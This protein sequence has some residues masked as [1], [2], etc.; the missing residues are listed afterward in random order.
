M[1]ITVTD[2]TGATLPGI[3]VEAVGVADRTGDTDESG[4]LRFTNLRPGAYR[5]R[6][7]GD[8][9]ITFEREIAVRNG[10]TTDVDVT[11]NPD[12]EPEEASE[13]APQA[14]TP[15]AAAPQLGPAG[16]PMTLDI[17]EFADR[18]LIRREPRRESPIACSGNARATL[19]QLNEPQPERLYDTAE[20]MYYVVAG[21]G[22]IRV[23]GRESALVAGTFAL[24][25]R[26]ASFTI[27]RKG[28]NPIV[29]LSVLTGEPCQGQ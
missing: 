29:L 23:N 11:L 3:H 9:V 1:T 17:P 28:R 24:V 26:G 10:Q 6:F 13:S 20:S 5:M 27:L 15:Q 21:E 2:P 14:P 22:T 19:V 16:Q 18:N 8:D 12:T 25:P 4:T 7:S